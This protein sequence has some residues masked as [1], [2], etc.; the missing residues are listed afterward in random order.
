M[1]K[2]VDLFR[3]SRSTEREE[4]EEGKKE[5]RGRCS[6]RMVVRACGFVSCLRLLQ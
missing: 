6:A 1:A 2:I 3:D 4:V 5:R